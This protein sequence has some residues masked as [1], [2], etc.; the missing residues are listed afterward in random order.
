MRFCSIIKL[1][2]IQ[3]RSVFLFPFHDILIHLVFLFQKVVRY[4]VHQTLLLTNY[5]RTL[6]LWLVVIQTFG[7]LQC[8]WLQKISSYVWVT[9]SFSVAFEVSLTVFFLTDKQKTFA[10]IHKVASLFQ[11]QDTSIA[12]SMCRYRPFKVG[13]NIYL[14]KNSVSQYPH[15]LLIQQTILFH[16]FTFMICL[17]LFPHRRSFH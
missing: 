16:L 14:K 9:K 12:R 7:Q 6:F 2:L 5:E 10:P 3:L 15:R 8:Q 4:F 1:M 13:R 11:I 17:G